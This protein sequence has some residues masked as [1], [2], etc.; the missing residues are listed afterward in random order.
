MSKISLFQGFKK[1]LERSS[2]S[3][4]IIFCSHWFIQKNNTFV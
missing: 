2:L 3:D 1:V 4:N